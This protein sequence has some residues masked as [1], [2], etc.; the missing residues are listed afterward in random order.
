MPVTIQMYNDLLNRVVALE[1]NVVS[2][3]TQLDAS[4]QG[5]ILQR[6]SQIEASM[7]SIN[8]VK[9]LNKTTNR[10]LGN[11][12][13][14]LISQQNQIK[15]INSMIQALNSWRLDLRHEVVFEQATNVS[16]NDWTLSNKYDPEAPMF[17]FQASLTLVDPAVINMSDPE[18]G[19]FTSGAVLTPD[20]WVFY[21]KGI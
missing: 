19:V 1:T 2:I 15:T 4:D 14:Q 6:L 5:S 8:Q 13:D 18:A 11:L 9:A 17:V 12:T 16:G 21:F 3:L 7:V 10:D 20:V